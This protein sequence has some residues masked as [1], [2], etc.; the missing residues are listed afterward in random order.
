MK[1]ITFPIINPLWYQLPSWKAI[2]NGKKRK[3]SSYPRRHGK[4]FEDLSIFSRESILNR[5]TYYYVFP[6][7]KWGERAIWETMA[8]IEVDGKIQTKPIIEWMFPKDICKHVPSDLRVEINGKH[9]KSLFFMGGTDNLDFVGQGGQGYCMSEFSLHKE[10]VTGLLAPIIR[11]S[12]ALLFLN[13]TMRGKNNPLF[14]ILKNTKHD[15]EWHSR[16]LKPEETKLYCWVNEDEGINV[17][18]ELLDL[19]GKIDPQTNDYYKNCQGVPYYNIQS[20][21]DSGL[22]SY[23]LARQEYLNRAENVV[24]GG[25]YGYEINKAQKD[26]RML[27]INPFDDIVYTFW[28]LGGANEENDSTSILFAHVNTMNKTFRVVD[29]YEVRGGERKDHW[30]YV[31]SK[32]YNYGGH[33]YPHDGKRTTNNWSGETAAESALRNIGIEVRF[34]PKTQNTLNDIEISR[35]GFVKTQFNTDLCGDLIEHLS[36]YHEKQSTGKPCHSYSCQ[37]CN[38]ASHGADTFRYMH[39]A[40]YH[41]LIE[42]YLQTRPKQYSWMSERETDCIDEDYFIV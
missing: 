34:I 18:P 27:S 17:N 5:G 19:V 4:D 33:F 12:Q 41:G 30:D 29:Y 37:E 32:N 3:I 6:T 11:Q 38:G 35:R 2:D 9:G 13:G 26:G 24:A 39:M 14:K 21:V 15:K 40:N 22:I 23:T 20:D 8:K 28:D 25:Y 36:S 16:W 42:P 10:A 1:N 7:R 31:L